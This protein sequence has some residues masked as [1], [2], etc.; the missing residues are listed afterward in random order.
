[1]RSIEIELRIQ[2]G[3]SGKNLSYDLHEKYSPNS[4]V[5]EQAISMLEKAL[6]VPQFVGR[7]SLKI[8]CRMETTRGM[9]RILKEKLVISC[10]KHE[11]VIQGDGDNFTHVSI[12]AN[13]R[14]ALL[15]YLKKWIYGMLPDR[16]FTQQS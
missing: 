1:M 2:F 12:G 5:E 13:V 3:Q 15:V 4:S 14:R 9:Q 8:H 10:A 16:G 11:C 7:D 6:Q